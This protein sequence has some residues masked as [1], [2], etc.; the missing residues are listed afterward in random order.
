MELNRLVEMGEHFYNVIIPRI[1]KVAFSSEWKDGKLKDNKQVNP[2]SIAFRYYEL[3]SYEEAL[4]HCEYVLDSKYN[5]Y[6]IESTQPKDTIY[7]T[8][9][10]H[11]TQKIINYRKSRKLIKKLIKGDII[12]IDMSDDYR[13]GFDIFTTMSNL[14]NLKIK[15]LFLAKDSKSIESHAN[16]T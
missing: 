9:D 14:L 13:E 8:N 3:E 1:K 15:R 2:M 7:N 12:A 10:Y 6:N 4:Q 5:T 16:N 11:K